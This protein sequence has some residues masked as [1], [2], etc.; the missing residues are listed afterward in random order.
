MHSLRG[1]T[2]PYYISLPFAPFLF[3]SLLY[4]THTP[5]FYGLISPFWF[6]P[7]RLLRFV[8]Q[9]EETHGRANRNE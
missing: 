6:I 7:V 8:L 1:W 2:T 5:S 4:R 9:V 3:Q